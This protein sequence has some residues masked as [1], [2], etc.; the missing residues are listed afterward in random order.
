MITVTAWQPLAI[1]LMH[2]WEGCAKKRPDGLFQAYP[3]P[4][5]ADGHPWTI[6]WGSTGPGIAKGTVWTQSQCNDRFED[7]LAKYGNEVA[8]FIGDAPT[9]AHQFAALVCFHYNTGKLA[10]STLLKKHKA[11]DYAGARAE[12]GKWIYNDGKVMQ[13]LVNRRADEA[14]LYGKADA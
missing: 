3:D 2:K 8:R 10:S 14:A 12:F 5:S 13:G 11:G 7:D 4:G 6:G 9:T 1:K